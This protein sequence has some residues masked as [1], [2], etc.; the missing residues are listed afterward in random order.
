MW[1]IVKRRSWDRVDAR[2]LLCAF[3][4]LLM[5][6]IW[7]ATLLQLRQ[8][9]DGAIADA[10]REVRGLA[11]VFDEH[12]VR[13]IEAADQA[14]TYLRHRY[15]TAGA[16]LDIAQDL[17]QGL[18]PGNLY[19]LFTIVDAHG[20]M[21]LSS[22]PF[23][24]TNLSDREH[25]RVH[26]RQDTGSL[27]ISKPVLGRV[28]KKW[29]IQ[30]TRRINHADGAFK[31]V[32]VVSMDPFYF[33]RLYDEVDL[34]QRSS[35]AMIGTDGV[36]RARRVGSANSIGQD[37]SGSALFGRMRGRERG[38]F[39]ERSPVDGVLR[40]Y[41]FEKMTNYPLYMLVGLDGTAVLAEYQSRRKQSLLLA[42]IS[43]A[44]IVLFCGALILLIG[45]LIDSRRRA[46]A[47]SLAKS[48]FLSN[49][50][51]ELRTPLNGILGFS[52][53]LLEQLDQPAQIKCAEA[54]AASGRK[55]LGM[56][57]AVLELSALESGKQQLRIAL[58]PLDELL[59]QAL[60]P[61]RAQAAAKGVA[62]ALSRQ[63]GLP[64]L[65]PCDRSKLVR[66]LDILLGNALEFTDAGHVTLRVSQQAGAC[67]F[68]VAD[69]GA[70]IAAERQAGIFDKF[71]QI[72]DAPSRA[73]SGAGLGL[74]TAARLAML[75]NTSI[76]LQS[77]PGKG[78]IF[79]LQ[80]KNG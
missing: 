77:A 30:M 52:E 58:S 79:G 56:I 32:V 33:T 27:F 20:D 26:A 3:V 37:I 28:S 61:H 47:A 29:S 45:R 22:Q 49:M 73:R 15:N 68:E 2:M 78:S 69:S 80:V 31:G 10:E 17:R 57:E 9:R 54:V 46:I 5:A 18:N 36:V 53:L 74:A 76:T 12:A 65:L 70:G 19:N 43:S 71:S 34:G 63:D 6:G 72:D 1:S 67:R 25:F 11:R 64:A 62:L 24:P 40:Y 60:A 21:V 50:S 55:L 35:I 44:A 42:G 48:R 8:A 75:M 4:V 39:V 41:A 23:K 38:S 51:H 16:A 14:V 7:G 59:E 66:V 13:T